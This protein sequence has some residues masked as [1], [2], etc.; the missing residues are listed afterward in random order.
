MKENTIYYVGWDIH[1]KIYFK[2]NICFLNKNMSIFLEEE[3]TKVSDNADAQWVILWVSY[4]K[5]YAADSTNSKVN[6][7]TKQF[8]KFYS[9]KCVTGNG[10]EYKTILFDA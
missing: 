2:G 7:N 4:N 6:Y 10:M 5:E 9:H 3:L 8:I 1:S